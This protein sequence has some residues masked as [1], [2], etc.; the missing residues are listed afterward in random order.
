MVP[1]RAGE[2]FGRERVAP[3]DRVAERG[4]VPSGRGNGSATADEN[5]AHGHLRKIKVA[6]APPKPKELLRAY[7]SFASV[8]WLTTGNE[9]TGSG[10]CRVEVGGSH[11]SCKAIRQTTASTAP[12]APSRW[13]ML[14]LVELTGSV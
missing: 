10:D 8:G 6:F 9:Q 11:C 13:P 2:I 5:G 14:D 4:N 1:S 7:S 3:I 12:A